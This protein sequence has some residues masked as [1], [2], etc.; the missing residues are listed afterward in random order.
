MNT[1]D[2][3]EM[4]SDLVAEIDYDIWKEIFLEGYG[5]AEEQ[6]QTRDNLIRMVL[7]SPDTELAY[8]R[9]RDQ[10]LSSLEAAGVDNWEGYGEIDVQG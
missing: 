5:D 7:I 8:L 4:I 3:V 1:E 6:K 2:A 9:D 10:L